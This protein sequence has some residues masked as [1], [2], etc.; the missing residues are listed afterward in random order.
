MSAPLPEKQSARV[1]QEL[2]RIASSGEVNEIVVASLERE[3]KNLM[4]TDPRGAYTALG[5][6]ASIKGNVEKIH[7]FHQIAIEYSPDKS[8]AYFNYGR[9]LAHI[10]DYV[11]A[12]AI[13]KKSYELGREHQTLWL[14]VEI[15]FKLGFI[16]MAK[17]YAD[18][19]FDRSGKEHP[20][21][22]KI[23]NSPI[24]DIPTPLNTSEHE[25]F[26]DYQCLIPQ[27]IDVTEEDYDFLLETIN[28]PTEPNEAL[29]R[30]FST[31]TA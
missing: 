5:A 29:K 12:L 19:Y 6:I 22:E 21:F 20:L 13:A 1:I 30:L 31:A 23:A 4:S 11:S 7:H 17:M 28:S 14:L 25:I 26:K 3:A 2:S 18:E 15:A 10:G 16:P 9:S 24:A 27:I 8:E